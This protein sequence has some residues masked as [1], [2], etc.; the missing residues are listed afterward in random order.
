MLAVTGGLRGFCAPALRPP[1]TAIGIAIAR[2]RT[3]RGPLFV[4][5]NTRRVTGSLLIDSIWTV[6]RWMVVR[7]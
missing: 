6:V 5:D 1:V 2:H 7:T 4:D 3:I